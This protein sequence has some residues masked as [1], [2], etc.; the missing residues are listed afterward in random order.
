M[1]Y[2]NQG[3]Y[4]RPS[5]FGGF[6]FFPPAVKWLLILNAAGFVL[7]NFF[8]Q[9]SFGDYSL[10]GLL[11]TYFALMPIGAG[12]LPWQVVSYQFMHWDFWHLFFNM[13][14]GLWMFGMEVEHT[15]GSKK[16]LW[17][18]L[19]CGV[20]AGIFQLILSPIFEPG[21]LIDPWGR[22]IPTV[23]A[24]GAVYG[25]LIAFAMFFPDRHIFLY[26]LIP[27]KA[28]YFV[29]F[30]ILLGVFSVG[31]TS[32]VANLAHLGGA[33]AGWVYILLDRRNVP[34]GGIARRVGWWF[35]SI[36]HPRSSD[37]EEDVG[38]A[39]VY[40]IRENRT[41]RG[42]R[43]DDRGETTQKQIDEILDKISR[44]GYQSL[45][46]EEKRILFEA[47]KKLH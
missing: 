46:E 32:N 2:S 38:E 25:I 47:S 28:K 26:F 17:F 23:G 3:G 30:I 6:S 21:A 43:E 31:G 35:N 1:A 22:G 40:D 18:Y 42:G 20:V 36:M 9:F 19:M 41:V 11:N 33:F 10:R 45:S 44:G 14:F 15:W 16:F 39:K 27:V 24:S 12:F 34:L 29:G 8:G 5:M 4:H 7:L 37:V 13:F